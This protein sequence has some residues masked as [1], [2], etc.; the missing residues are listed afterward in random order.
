MSSI[1]VN[2]IKLSPADALRM[3]SVKEACRIRCRSRSSM[4]RDVKAGR[5]PA[6]VEIGPGRKG[7]RFADVVS[8]K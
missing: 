5:F 6:P 2:G 1:V 4:W 7:W 8:F 3:V